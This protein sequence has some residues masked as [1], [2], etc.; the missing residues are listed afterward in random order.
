MLPAKH[1]EEDI[2][3]SSMTHVATLVKSKEIAG[4]TPV[5]LKCKKFF[6]A[7]RL[8]AAV[9]ASEPS[10]VKALVL[11]VFLIAYWMFR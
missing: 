5:I 11:S 10:G 8:Q 7:G 9:V 4:E 1:A 2:I 3:V 6:M